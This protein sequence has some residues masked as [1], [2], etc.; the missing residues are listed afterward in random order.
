MSRG[1]CV[2]FLA[3]IVTGVSVLSGR[4]SVADDLSSGIYVTAVESTMQECGDQIAT[5]SPCHGFPNLQGRVL[6]L[7]ATITLDVD[8]LWPTL[9]AVIHNAVWEGSEP[10]ELEVASN[11]AQPSGDG[12]WFHGDY[13]AAGYLFDWHFSMSPDGKTLWNGNAYWSGGH[14]WQVSFEDVLVV[15]VP[16]PIAGGPFLMLSLLFA[17]LRASVSH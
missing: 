14:I 16:E 8:S 3:G 6:P 9:S 12:Y 2:R 15:P 7:S 17:R 11:V 1:G 5:G 13:F 10:F 4:P